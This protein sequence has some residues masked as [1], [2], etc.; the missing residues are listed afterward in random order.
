M[1][2]RSR[3]ADPGPR[4]SRGAALREAAR[5]YY[6]VESPYKYDRVA[7]AR[8]CVLWR[9]GEGLTGY[10]EEILA[11]LDEHHRVCVRGP[12]GIGKTA[13]DA[14]VVLHFATT[15]DVEQIDWKNPTVASAWRQLTHFLWPEIRKWARRLNWNNIGRDPFS[16]HEM[17]KQNLKLRTGEAFAVASD[18]ASAIEGAHADSILYL[19]DESKTIP[20]EVWD[21]IEGAF[22]G[23]GADT[24]AESFALANSTPGEPSG[25]FF[26]IQTRKPG[27]EDW[28][29]IHVTLD[30]AIAAG[31]ISREWAD[32]R[33]RQWGAKSPVYRN[34]VLGE[35]A[36]Q[37]RDSVIPLAWVEAAIERWQ[38]AQVTEGFDKG[39]LRNVGIDVARSGD[40]KTVFARRY[41]VFYDEL[42]VTEKQTTMDT[43]NLAYPMVMAP[44]VWA[45]VDVVG[46]GAGVV[47]RLRELKAD[48]VAFNG[49]ESTPML[50]RSGEVGFLNKRA[51]S[52]WNLREMLDPD[53]GDDL[54]LPPDDELIGDLTAPKWRM[55]AGG[56]IQIE[57]KEDVQK[58][59]GRSPDR[60]DA[61]VYAAWPER[62]VVVKSAFG[63]KKTG[64][65]DDLL[66]KGF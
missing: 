61:V 65:T 14:F 52:W 63:Q 34:R 7:W 6:T 47:D 20:P 50:D 53:N 17:L 12:H 35:F 31:R 48:A 38:A 21:A 26:D 29:V 37:D 59:I 58:R 62:P 49:A 40:D 18:D 5:A 27:Y 64:L 22:S 9:P 2:P 60:G 55:S 39:Q 56:K 11:A 36:E 32:Q 54:M 1:T 66:T 43:A 51:A 25:R 28:H 30:D 42:I 8:D 19:L 4:V 13:I 16:I 45:T 23:A 10:Q 15:R 24:A 57:K 3:A 46:L 44:G 33:L 41:G